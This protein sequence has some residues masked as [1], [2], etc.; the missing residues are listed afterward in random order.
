PVQ[1]GRSALPLPK[2]RPRAEAEIVPWIARPLER[3]QHPWTMSW[4]NVLDYMPPQKFHQLARMCSLQGDTI[5]YGYSMNWICEVYGSCIMD[6]DKQP[7]VQSE[8]IK[9]SHQM[10]EM[11]G[12]MAPAGKLLLLPP[13]DSPMNITGYT[14]AIG[15]HK[16]WTQYFFSEEIA[17]DVQVG[18]ASMQTYNPLATTASCLSM[19]WTYDPDIR[20][21]AHDDGRFLDDETKDLVNCPV[22]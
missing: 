6:Y 10:C 4:S 11:T 19:T 14:L 3:R 8:I 2:S 5:H 20:L 12:K 21:Q 15:L 7:Q 22:S 16:K 1:T 17:G 9:Q 13:H 18:V